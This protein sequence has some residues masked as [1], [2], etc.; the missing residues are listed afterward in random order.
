[1]QKKLFLSITALF[2]LM[3]FPGSAQSKSGKIIYKVKNSKNVDVFLKKKDANER[4]SRAIKTWLTNINK[5]LPYIHFELLFNE[6]EALFKGATNMSNDNG[7]DLDRSE[8]YVG[9]GG[10]FYTNQ[11]KAVILHQ[12]HYADR[13]W[14]IRRS[15]DSLDWHITQETKKIQGYTCYKA[16]LKFKGATFVRPEKITAWFSPEIPLQFG[17]MNYAGLPGLILEIQH[18]YWT[19]YANKITFN[20]KQ[21]QI[22]RPT[23][24]E[25]I[26]LDD[27]NK[28]RKRIADRRKNQIQQHN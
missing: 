8:R 10:H 4:Q 7:L 27:Y 28:K 23:K 25:L 18:M 21:K 1:M 5:T 22:K 12:L 26:N 24:G 15:I 13:N 19:I 2:F 6:Q 14:I 9:G 16:T 20:K 11:K 3:S 17:P